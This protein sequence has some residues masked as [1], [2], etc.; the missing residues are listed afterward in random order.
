MKL[1]AWATS[2]AVSVGLKIGISSGDVT[3]I[4][5]PLR[6]IQLFFRYIQLFTALAQRSNQIGVTASTRIKIVINGKI[7]I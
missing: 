7:D 1:A 2:T 5:I 4:K 3:I 6:H